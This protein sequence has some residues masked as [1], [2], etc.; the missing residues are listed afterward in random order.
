MPLLRNLQ[1]CFWSA[2]PLP[3][4]SDS[5]SSMKVINHFLC[6]HP[7]DSLYFQILSVKSLSPVLFT[8]MC[9]MCKLLTLFT[10]KHQV[11]FDFDRDHDL[12]ATDSRISEVT[13]RKCTL[14][15]SMFDSYFNQ[16]PSLIISYPSFGFHCI[17]IFII[18]NKNLLKF[19]CRETLA[20]WD[21]LICNFDLILIFRT[22]NVSQMCIIC[23]RIA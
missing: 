15:Q 17:L 10:P 4:F 14:W 18:I 23:H 8:K 1:F 11:N 12:M 22:F 16:G 19:R 6:A 20:R 5:Y 21:R 9:I 7:H 13:V 3:R 2:T